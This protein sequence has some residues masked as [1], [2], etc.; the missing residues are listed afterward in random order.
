MDQSRSGIPSEPGHAPAPTAEE[1]P[2][3]SPLPKAMYEEADHFTAGPGVVMT[4]SQA[5]G[6]IAGALMGLFV[7]A[8]IGLVIGLIAFDANTGRVISVVAVAVAGSVAG[9]VAG[10]I[11]R[12][13]QKMEKDPADT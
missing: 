5:V 8:L 3:S 10:G 12:P 7:G 6:G 9:G 1:T 13:M 2:V 4:R 11:V